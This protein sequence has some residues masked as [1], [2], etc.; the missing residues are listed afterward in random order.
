MANLQELLNKHCKELKDMTSKND[1]TILLKLHEGLTED[2]TKL[3]ER[4]KGVMLPTQTR[5]QIKGIN[6][7]EEKISNVFQTLRAI[8]Q[9]E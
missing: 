6:E 9:D 4:I 5:Y 8:A 1:P 7:L 3:M 2:L